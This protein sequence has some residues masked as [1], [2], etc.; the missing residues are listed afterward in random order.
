MG[1]KEPTI[2]R[3]VVLIMR[4]RGYYVRSELMAMIRVTDVFF[5]SH[6]SM[7]PSAALICGIR[8]L[9]CCNEY[10]IRVIDY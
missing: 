10:R 2:M 3:V 4:T 7:Q 6:Y 5:Y 8:R 1:Q 9:Q